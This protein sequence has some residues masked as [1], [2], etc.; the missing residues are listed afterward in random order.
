MFPPAIW[1]D[2]SVNT[3]FWLKIDFSGSGWNFF[4]FLSFY[5]QPGACFRILPPFR[6]RSPFP[7]ALPIILH[8]E[9]SA[10]GR[11]PCKSGSHP[12]HH[13]SDSGCFLLILP[14]FPD[15]LLYAHFLP[16]V[17]YELCC[18]SQHNSYLQYS[19]DFCK[20]LMLSGTSHRSSHGVLLQQDTIPRIYRL[21]ETLYRKTFKES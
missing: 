3:L 21:S 5:P 1:E 16:F 8:F 18:Q 13:P 12:P 10:P 17:K 9:Q 20:I 15:F 4:H 14:F 6:S 19:A 11:V 2:F 7:P